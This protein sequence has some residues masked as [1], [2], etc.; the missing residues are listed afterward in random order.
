MKYRFNGLKSPLWGGLHSPLFSPF[1]GLAIAGGSGGGGGSD[2]DFGNVVALLHFDGS[3]GSGTFIDEI[4]HT[5]TKTGTPTI[6]TAQSVFGGA[7]GFFPSG[8]HALTSTDA[9]FLLVGDFT[10]E[11]WVRFT[12]S[13]KADVMGIRNLSTGNHLFVYKTSSENLRFTWAGV[14]KEVAVS[15]DTWYYFAV[16]RNGS[17]WSAYLDGVELGSPTITTATL[18]GAVEFTIGFNANVAGS[19]INGYLDDVR[20]TNGVA[21]YTSDFTPPSEAFPDA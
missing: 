11:G 17:S 9:D 19:G 20:V 16:V 12:A 21:R 2:P 14:S 18:S 1:G 3:N 13:S 4:G 10:V 6:S 7:S 5:F 15:L 8:N